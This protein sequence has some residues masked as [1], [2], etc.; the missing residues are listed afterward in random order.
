LQPAGEVRD[1][2]HGRELARLGPIDRWILVQHPRALG[3][4]LRIFGAEQAVRLAGTRVFETSG[5]V[6][7]TYRPV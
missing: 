6:A 5:S 2:G 3:E 4:G 7:L 1:A